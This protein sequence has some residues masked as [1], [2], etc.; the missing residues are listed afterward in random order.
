MANKYAQSA[1]NWSAGGGGG[2]W[3]DA[4]A[5]GSEVAKPGVGDDAYTN[6]N[7]VTLD[8]NVVCDLVTAS[9]TG[10][11]VLVP[12]AATVSITA[13]VQ[14]AFAGTM[15]TWAAANGTLTI[16][17]DV[18]Y[19]STFTSGMLAVGNGQ[20]LL[21]NGITTCSG[22]GTAIRAMGSG[23]TTL[24][25]SGNTVVSNTG[26]GKGIQTANGTVPVTITG[27][28]VI[29]DGIGAQ[30]D[31]SSVN[32]SFTGNL[33]STSTNGIDKALILVN[34]TLT[35]TPGSG[36][37]A[38]TLGASAGMQI[39]G[40]GAVLNITGNVSTAWSSAG[41][42]IAGPIYLTVG[43]INWTGSR[44]LADGTECIIKQVGGTLNFATASAKLELANSGTLICLVLGGTF[45]T[46]DAGAGAASIVNQNATSYAAFLN[47]T[48]GQRAIITGPAGGGGGMLVHPGTS[49]GARG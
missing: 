19:A 9:T 31:G 4:P 42:A 11:G 10:G 37:S 34:G 30:L 16:N 48:A 29:S 14:S 36:T 46:A 2:I 21:V 41:N 33:V 12:S 39:G 3:F 1:G 45:N 8:E 5:A 49:G 43:I 20:T 47:A 18:T 44:T 28:I 22:T 27:N 26:N 7:I 13:D 35:W 15:L 38:L 23:S 24:T 40:N 17:G 6:G 25:N 32:K